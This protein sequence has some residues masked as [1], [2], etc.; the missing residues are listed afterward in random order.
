MSP[1]ADGVPA[2]RWLKMA[3]FVKTPKHDCLGWASLWRPSD[4]IRFAASGYPARW[5]GYAERATL[6]AIRVAIRGQGK[7]V[8]SQGSEALGGRVPRLSSGL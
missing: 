6:C 3:W 7:D 4:A 5:T 1:G 8:A 2:P